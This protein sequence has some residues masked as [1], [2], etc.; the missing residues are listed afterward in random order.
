V[1]ETKRE[2]ETAKEID[3]ERHTDRHKDEDC[4]K[5]KK[6]HIKAERNIQ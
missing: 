2:R 4:E 1:R 3:R 5:V 6:H